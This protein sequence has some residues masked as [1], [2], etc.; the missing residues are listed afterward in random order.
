VRLRWPRSRRAGGAS[1]NFDQSGSNDPKPSAYNHA[2]TE[3]RYVDV[4]N[5]FWTNAFG[6]SASSRS[7]VVAKHA[8]VQDARWAHPFFCLIERSCSWA[9]LTIE[10]HRYPLT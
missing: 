7:S 6:F 9:R 5:V 1:K 4:N 3:R 10:N 8:H 2:N